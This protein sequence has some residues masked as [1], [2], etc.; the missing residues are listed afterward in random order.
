MKKQVD[1]RMIANCVLDGKTEQNWNIK[2]E[3]SYNNS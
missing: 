3:E 2:W 1:D